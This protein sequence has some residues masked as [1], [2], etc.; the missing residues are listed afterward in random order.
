MRVLHS[1]R[2]KS[3]PQL[4]ALL[5]YIVE[6]SIRGNEESLKE[7]IIGIDVF[8]RKVDYDTSDDPIVRSRVGQLRKRLS[9]FY[10]SNESTGSTI[11][12]VI[13]NGSYRPQ[14][15]LRTGTNVDP[16]ATT[17][18]NVE[19]IAAFVRTEP[20]EA[21]PLGETERSVSPPSV[22]FWRVVAVTTV[23][24]ALI[25][26]A[27]ASFLKFRKTELDLLWAPMIK[28]GR[29]VLLYNGTI[30]VYLPRAHDSAHAQ[31]SA[32]DNLPAE[33]P[34]PPSIQDRGAIPTDLMRYQD[35][36]AAPGDIAAD[37]K[38]ATLL[39]SLGRS[40]NLRTGADLPYIDLKNSPT[41]LIG[42]YDNYWT[43]HLS[44]ELPFFLDRAGRI[45]ERGGKQRS[46]SSTS[47]ADSRITEDYALVFRLVGSKDANPILAIA[48][49]TSCGTQ[50]AAEFV[51]DAAQAR[52]LSEIPRNDLEYKN[53]EVVLHTSLV[54]CIPT[55]VD[56][57]AQHTW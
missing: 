56:V 38:V 18:K 9:Q 21:K 55:S 40:V 36:L 8:G 46:W 17:P 27:G 12:I 34:L 1:S 3:S 43:L 4:Q 50:A 32:E 16:L 33:D 42:A 41:T 49:L 22:S 15:L 45:H 28:S 35:G 52:K 47:Q 30:S 5:R 53:L 31:P 54:N 23:V 37:I 13:S 2:F 48:G 19:P 7:R 20:G 25:A 51:T 26:T 11:Q 57:I 10:E 44:R 39:S 24:I 6:G 29:P 14:F